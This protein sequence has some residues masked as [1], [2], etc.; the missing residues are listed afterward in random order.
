VIYHPQRNYFN[1]PQSH[2]NENTKENLLK[3]YA[4]EKSN[5]DQ[6]SREAI[7]YLKV[8][9]V[10]DATLITCP[11]DIYE[12]QAIGMSTLNSANEVE[13]KDRVYL[14]GFVIN[15]PDGG[16]DLVGVTMTTKYGLLSLNPNHLDKL[17][18]NSVSVCLE[19]DWVCHGSGSSD[20]RL[21]FAGFP[22]HVE[23]AL[24]GMTYQTHISGVTD[25]IVLTIHDD[26]NAVN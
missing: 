23:R 3:F 19:S 25:T 8:V 10:N 1:S 18:F 7:Q 5:S 20:Q 17:D 2:F 11:S 16:S 9:N 4:Q 26:Y 24:N 15:D 13:F 14:T 6:H 22:Q 12:V 21:Q